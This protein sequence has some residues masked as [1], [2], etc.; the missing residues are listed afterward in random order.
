M[1]LQQ[2]C[3]SCGDGPSGLEMHQ[4]PVLVVSVY[5]LYVRITYVRMASRR[6]LGHGT[7]SMDL[8]K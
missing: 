1:W 8:S 6:K 5:A 7:V 3:V 2:V 4:T